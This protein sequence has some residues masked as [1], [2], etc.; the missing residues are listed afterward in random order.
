MFQAAPGCKILAIE[1][2]AALLFLQSQLFEMWRWS[3][4]IT[5]FTRHT[6]RNRNDENTG[7]AALLVPAYRDGRV[8]LPWNGVEGRSYIRE[9]IRELIFWPNGKTTD[10]VM[11]EWTGAANLSKII[12][13]VK[14]GRVGSVITL[15]LPRE[16][17]LNQPQSEAD[18]EVAEQDLPPWL[19]SPDTIDGQ[20]IRQH[21]FQRVP[22]YEIERSAGVAV[23]LARDRRS[24]GT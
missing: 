12:A 15:N 8:R 22:D 1:D 11:A 24:D 13:T 4:G 20:P 18:R 17:H 3:R 7:V 2:N 16:R 6:D 23:P 9:K 14:T 21:H 5:V 10:T 19:R